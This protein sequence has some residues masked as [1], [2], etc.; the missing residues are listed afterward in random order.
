LTTDAPPAFHLLAKP[1]GAVG[2]L[3][4]SDGFFF[5]TEMLYSGSRSRMANELLEAYIRQLLEAQA[6]APVVDVAWQAGVR[7]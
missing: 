5:S 2:N 6:R 7:H 3:D 4:C 1:T